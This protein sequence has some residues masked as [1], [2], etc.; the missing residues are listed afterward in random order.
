MFNNS[1]NRDYKQLYLK[2]KMKYINLKEEL[3]GGMF[4]KFESSSKKNFGNQAASRQEINN[5]TEWLGEV[6]NYPEDINDPS[7]GFRRLRKEEIENYL[8]VNTALKGPKERVKNIDNIKSV[9]KTFERMNFKTRDRELTQDRQREE[10]NR[11]ELVS[12]TQLSNNEQVAAA[13]RSYVFADG[14]KIPEDRIQ[15]YVTKKGVNMN[16]SNVTDSKNINKHFKDLIK[17]SNE[18][19]IV[20][21]TARLSSTTSSTGDLASLLN[22]YRLPDGGSL[23]NEL[24]VAYLNRY[25]KSTE[26]KEEEIVSIIGLDDYKKSLINSILR[27]NG[28]EFKFPDGKTL[29][30]KEKTNFLKEVKNKKSPNLKSYQDD[31][32]KMFRSKFPKKK[33]GKK[34]NSGSSSSV[35]SSISSPVFTPT[36]ESINPSNILGLSTITE[37]E[38]NQNRDII[39]FK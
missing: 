10:A 14:T 3:E 4:G 8:K 22:N 29:S 37:N 26:I 35:S 13:L 38:E 24:K 32:D 9:L 30:P 17:E 5:V 12:S 15:D 28:E 27:P 16:P 20:Q 31:F 11:P 39:G 23:P 7:K 6:D 18:N 2:Y 36:S 21:T 19:L 34:S 33:N 1:D 25:P